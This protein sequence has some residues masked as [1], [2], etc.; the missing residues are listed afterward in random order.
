LGTRSRSRATHAGLRRAIPVSASWASFTLT[1][2]F[3]SGAFEFTDHTV[4]FFAIPTSGVTTSYVFTATQAT[5]F[6]AQM[7]GISEA[8]LPYG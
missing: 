1:T 8:V 5:L 3:R 2:D 6:S 4:R 7:F